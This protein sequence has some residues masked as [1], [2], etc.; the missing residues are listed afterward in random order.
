MIDEKGK[1]FGKINVLDLIFILVIIAAVALAGMLI[2]NRD[3][4]EATVSTDYVV[5]IKNMEEAYFDNAIIGETVK[6]GVTGEYVGEIVAFEKKPARVL[7]EAGNQMKFAEPQGRFDGYVTIR[8]QSSVIYPDLMV[9]N[10]VIKIGKKVAYRSESLA[11][12]GYIVDI[13]FDKKQTKEAQ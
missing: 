2:L 8:C 13:N 11:M 7:V 9:S 10:Q 6:D 1:L 5:E 12:H 3:S 4:I